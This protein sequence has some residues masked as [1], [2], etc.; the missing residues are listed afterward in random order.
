M[1]SLISRRLN[2]RIRLTRRHQLGRVA[3]APR[4]QRE[5][6]HLERTGDAG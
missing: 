2:Q 1:V 4:L 3:V 6:P 5:L